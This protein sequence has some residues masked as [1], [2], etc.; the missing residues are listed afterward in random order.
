MRTCQCRGC[1]SCDT[2]RSYC[3]LLLERL[4]APDFAD[5]P[6]Q[7]PLIDMEGRDAEGF[8]DGYAPTNS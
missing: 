4:I 1:T 8:A 6:Y 2:Y 5:L 7:E 3:P